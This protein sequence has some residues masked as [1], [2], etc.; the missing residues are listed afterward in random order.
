MT[1]MAISPRFATSTFS[2]IWGR[3]GYRPD[4][5]ATVAPIRRAASSRRWSR[6]ARLAAP[7]RRASVQALRQLRAQLR[8]DERAARPERERARA[9]AP[10]RRA[11]QGAPAGRRHPAAARRAR[12]RAGPV[13]NGRVRRVGA[14]RALPGLLEARRD[15]LRPARH[16]PVRAPALPPAGAGEPVRRRARRRAS[17]LASSAR[18]A[19]STRRATP[20]TTSTRCRQALGAERIALWGTSY[21]TKVALSYARRY[22]DRV[23]RLVLDSVAPLDGPDP[24]YR[25]STAAVPRVLRSLCG[26]AVR[27][28]HRPGGRPE[29]AGPA[30]R[31][32]RRRPPR[33][34][35]GR[36]RPAQ[37]RPAH[38]RGPLLDPARRR[39]R[40]HPARGLPRRGRGGARR[41]RHADAPPAA[42]RDRDR[43]RAPAAAPAQLRGVRRHDVRGGP[44]AV[45]A[46]HAARRGR[47]AP[48]R[49]G[50]RRH[51]SRFGVRAIRPRHGAGERHARAV[52]ELARRAGGAGSRLRAVPGRARAARRGRRR[53]AHA[54]RERRSRRRSRSRARRSSSLPTPATPPSARTSTAARSGRSRGSSSAG[55][56]RTGAGPGRTRSLPRRRRRG[57]YR[58]SCPCVARAAIAEGRLRR[59]S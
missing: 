44:D 59:R 19:P 2:N 26:R 11:R 32:P 55:G 4:A 53:P 9:R 47:A 25:D 56:F 36:A 41:R 30:D 6:R 54:G 20:T 34:R 23:E 17:A 49:R 51:H 13:R 14:E 58:P 18:G 8:P 29:P 40:P 1:R 5:S 48:A 31:R 46:R 33:H 38:A 12:R 28:D 45:A 35:G 42:A 22:P 37:A 7:A 10:V 57:G 24:Y 43:R 21:G 52:R 50:G 15:H 27:V 16:G 3:G 39:L